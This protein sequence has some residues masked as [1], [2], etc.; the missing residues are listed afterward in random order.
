MANINIPADDIAVCL[1]IA[2]NADRAL[3]VSRGEDLDSWGLPGGKV[4][5]I[6]R[7]LLVSRGA[8]LESWGF[9]GGKV[10]AGDRSL[11][12]AVCREALEEAGISLKPEDIEPV[13]AAMDHGR[14]TVTYDVRVD[15]NI[16]IPVRSPQFVTKE[17]TA[18][19]RPVTDVLQG[20][21]AEYNND[22]FMVRT[23]L[24]ELDPM[25]KLLLKLVRQHD[26]T[27]IAREQ[28]W[29]YSGTHAAIRNIRTTTGDFPH[30]D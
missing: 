1:V 26:D 9:P 24:K 18:D 10:E 15:S 23:G 2:E 22:F 13:Y 8:D 19:W 7:S 25:A 6:D 4:E 21:F 5:A 3:L 12:L 27:I 30:E 11:A 20:P 16:Q 17:G 28:T 29:Q 14:L